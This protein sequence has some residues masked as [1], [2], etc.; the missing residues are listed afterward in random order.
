MGKRKGSR[1]KES[2]RGFV[3]VSGVH[4]GMYHLRFCTHGDGIRDCRREAVNVKGCVGGNAGEE[5]PVMGGV[6]LK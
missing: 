5:G 6:V 4:I 2:W 3:I 1:G